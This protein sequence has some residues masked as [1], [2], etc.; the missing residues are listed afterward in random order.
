MGR[1]VTN[2]LNTLHGT[3]FCFLLHRP[4]NLFKSTVSY[5]ICRSPVQIVRDSIGRRLSGKPLGPEVTT[6]I[7]LLIKQ[8]TSEATAVCACVAKRSDDSISLYSTSTWLALLGNRSLKNLFENG[9]SSPAFGIIC[10]GTYVAYDTKI[11]AHLHRH[12]DHRRV[13]MLLART[14]SRSAADRL[15]AIDA[16]A[17]WDRM[18]PIDFQWSPTQKLFLAWS[19]VQSKDPSCRQT[20]SS[21]ELA[22]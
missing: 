5:K 1:S 21:P 19:L 4:T 17:W 14:S 9:A 12:L 15:D 16:S 3:V 20:S 18:N 8:R 7:K 22:V 2:W 6:T 11:D 10:D 13:F